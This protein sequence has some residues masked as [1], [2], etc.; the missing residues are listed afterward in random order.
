P[1]ARQQPCPSGL[2][3]TELFG[4]GSSQEGLIRVVDAREFQ[5]D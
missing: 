3:N 5:N 1:S 4:D 2:G